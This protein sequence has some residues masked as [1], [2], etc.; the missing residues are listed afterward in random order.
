V[1]RLNVLAGARTQVRAA[2]GRLRRVWLLRPLRPGFVFRT[3]EALV[4]EFFAALVNDDAVSSQRWLNEIS[5]SGRLSAENQRFF[6][7]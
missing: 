4:R 6:G 3:T 2:L 1:Y 5:L 7:D